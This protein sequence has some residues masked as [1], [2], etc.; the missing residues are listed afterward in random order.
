MD[1]K[2]HWDQLGG[3]NERTHSVLQRIREKRRGSATV[4]GECLSNSIIVAFHF[5][6]IRRKLQLMHCTNKAESWFM[7]KISL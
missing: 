3:E 6:L 5:I 2:H 4:Q 1:I 7:M